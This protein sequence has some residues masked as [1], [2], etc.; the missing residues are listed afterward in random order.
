MS[1]YRF[2]PVLG[3]TTVAFGVS[4]GA[5]RRLANQKTWFL[6]SLF[7][8]RGVPE[9]KL[10]QQDGLPRPFCG[11]MGAATAKFWDNF[12]LEEP[13]PLWSLIVGNSQE[14]CKILERT[15]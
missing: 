6:I 15:R 5:K 14:L 10:S 3:K 4:W 13:R 12:F 2:F 11:G 7:L 8:T 9:F 1:L